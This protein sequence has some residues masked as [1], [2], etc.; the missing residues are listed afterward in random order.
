MSAACTTVSRGVLF[1]EQSYW[2]DREA[3]VTVLKG[4]TL[5]R[6]AC[7]GWYVKLVPL[8]NRKDVRCLARF[9]STWQA[10]AKRQLTLRA[11]INLYDVLQ[12]LKR[13]DSA[14]SALAAVQRTGQSP[15]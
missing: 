8:R 3:S 7:G 14:I 15:R 11:I 1:W 4:I 12:A 2:R 6:S 9:C 13:G 10:G 5:H